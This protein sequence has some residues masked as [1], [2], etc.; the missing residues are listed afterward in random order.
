MKESLHRTSFARPHQVH[1]LILVSHH[2]RLIFTLRMEKYM[3]VDGGPWSDASRK[4]RCEIRSMQISSYSHRTSCSTNNC[5]LHES[6]LGP[7]SSFLRV[8]NPTVDLALET[9]LNVSDDRR[10]S[11][12]CGFTIR[13]N[14]D[15]KQSFVVNI[16]FSSQWGVRILGPHVSTSCCL[17]GPLN[18]EQFSFS[19]LVVQLQQSFS[20]EPKEV[21]L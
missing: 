2:L 17:I 13:W 7:W 14:W 12:T 20:G 5:P 16:S 10:I 3:K 9:I 21:F 1:L 18:E 6:T 19:S 8:Q 11:P 15:E 4:H